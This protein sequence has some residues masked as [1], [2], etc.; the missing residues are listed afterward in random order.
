[1]SISSLKGE[2]LVKWE[3]E[4]IERDKWVKIINVRFEEGV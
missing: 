2:S 1:M 4:I 3:A